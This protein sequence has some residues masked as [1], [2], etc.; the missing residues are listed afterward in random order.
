VIH[1]IIKGIARISPILRIPI[2]RKRKGTPSKRFRL[3]KEIARVIQPK[4]MA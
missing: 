3:A 1:E 4:A 2:E